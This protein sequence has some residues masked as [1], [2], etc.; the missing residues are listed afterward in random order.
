LAEEDTTLAEGG[1]EEPVPYDYKVEA[2]KEPEDKDKDKDRVNKIIEERAEQLQ[3][4]YLKKMADLRE[5]VQWSNI[6]KAV[7]QDNYTLNGIDFKYRGVSWDQIDEQDALRKAFFAMDRA[8]DKEMYKQNI[9]ARCKIVIE[10]FK[11]EDFNK[12]DFYALENLLRAWET[13]SS[14]GFRSI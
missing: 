5:K 14:Q 6:E 4:E 7:I 1:K 8:K 9:I 13:K 11:D 10:D 2:G 12:V 3:E